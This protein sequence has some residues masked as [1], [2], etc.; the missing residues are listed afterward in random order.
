MGYSDRKN[1]FNIDGGK[2]HSLLS[3]LL[4]VAKLVLPIIF[5]LNQGYQENNINDNKQTDDK[6]KPDGTVIFG[7]NF[8]YGNSD[9]VQ[10][11]N[12]GH[13]GPKGDTGASGPIGATGAMGNAGTLSATQSTTAVML[14]LN[15]RVPVLSLL[16]TPT[17]NQAVKLDSMS[18]VEITGTVGATNQY[19]ISYGLFRDG[20][21]ISSISVEKNVEKDQGSTSL[22]GKAFGEVPNITWVDTPVAGSY[23]YDIEI[24]VTGT[25]ITSA[26]AFARSLNALVI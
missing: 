22:S 18:E 10:E 5:K 16:V 6:N 2:Q 14:P 15:F 24:T 9:T 17:V 11:D 4:V 19:K 23:T 20:V 1:D 13:R 21:L 7:N 12:I 26:T 3:L 25:N 8:N